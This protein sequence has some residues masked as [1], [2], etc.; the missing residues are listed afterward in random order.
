[1]VAEDRG[2]RR[3]RWYV[4]GDEMDVVGGRLAERVADILRFLEFWIIIL[5]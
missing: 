1:M 3:Q 4:A 2:G 5:G